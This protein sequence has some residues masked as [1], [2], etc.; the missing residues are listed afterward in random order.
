LMLSQVAFANMVKYFDK[1]LIWFRE[2][3]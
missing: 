1:F 2:R 3:A